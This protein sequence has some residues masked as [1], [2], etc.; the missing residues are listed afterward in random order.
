MRAHRGNIPVLPQTKLCPYC[1][2]KFTRTTHLNRHLRTHTGERLHRCD[3]CDAQFTRSDL[4]T[5]HKKTCG[6]S[7]HTNRSRRRSCQACADSKIKCDL[8]QPCGKCISRGKECVFVARTSRL[9]TRS[10]IPGNPIA[11]DRYQTDDLSNLF[12]DAPASGPPSRSSSTLLPDRAQ[13]IATSQE[14]FLW[15]SSQP[16]IPQP[17]D[18]N[19]RSTV[20]SP[21]VTETV[22]STTNFGSSVVSGPVPVQ[23]HLHSLYSSDVLA[24]FFNDIFSNYHPNRVDS[25]HMGDINNTPSP[26]SSS[27]VEE[28][29]P[30]STHHISITNQPPVVPSADG[31]TVFDEPSMFVVP[32]Q[33]RDEFQHGSYANVIDSL[34]G[35]QGPALVEQQHYLYLFFSAFLVQM[36]LIH[37]YT[38]TMGAKSPVLVKAMQVCGALYVK[39]R[40]AS[41]FIMKTLAEA[42][43]LLF[44]EFAKSST[45]IR[46]QTHLVLAVVLIQAVGL[47][48]QNA[49]ERACSGLYHDMLILM[50]R[51]SRLIA[52]NASWEP[53]IATNPSM[54]DIEWRDWTC[55]EATKRGFLL[56]YVH[57]CTR[58]M[59]ALPASYTA[60]E[61]D[62]YLPCDDALW[63]ARSAEEWYSILQQPSPYGDPRSRLIGVHMLSALEAL[64]PTT[65]LTSPYMCLNPYALFVLIHAILRRLFAFGVSTRMPGA[66]I[67]SLPEAWQSHPEAADL[68]IM[69]VQYA[70]HSW[71]KHWLKATETPGSTEPPEEPPF[72]SNALPFYWLAQVSIMAYQERIPPFDDSARDNRPDAT[73]RLVKQWLRHI[74]DF[75]RKSDQMPTLFWDELMKMRL[76]SW[77]E[78][79][80]GGIPDD[81]EGLLG[82]FSNL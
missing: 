75:L 23:S 58:C 2:A 31:T 59:V 53:S 26:D 51:R 63:K 52:R 7:S 69:M 9:S 54:Y 39:T 32:Q 25:S 49:E 13:D 20:Y 47:F 37:A 19:R 76:Q 68:E 8:Q 35:L 70:L 64:Y 28:T 80:Q 45:D 22:D 5:R 4:L 65:N 41:S 60:T 38:F 36:P 48:H 11:N 1:P 17:V 6:D 3:T 46:A 66:Q 73:F 40:T 50:I 16:E 81:P 79:M 33:D 77:Q 74:R 44:Q 18:F 42:R 30:F 62:L 34:T 71:L 21:S 82:L 57:D 72:S 24:P 10:K 61:V 43:E 67:I 15:N 12:G 29:F 56:S 14:S 78:E 55:H 27:S